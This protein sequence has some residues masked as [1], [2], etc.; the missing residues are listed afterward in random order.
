MKAKRRKVIKDETRQTIW[1]VD[2]FRQRRL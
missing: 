2:S 1:F